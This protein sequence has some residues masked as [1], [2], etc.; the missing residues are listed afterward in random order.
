MKPKFENQL[1]IVRM[2]CLEVNIVGNL[3]VLAEV[4]AL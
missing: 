1:Q 2:Y 3:A 4:C